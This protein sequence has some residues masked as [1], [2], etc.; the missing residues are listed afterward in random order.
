MVIIAIAQERRGFLGAENVTELL[1]EIRWQT[2]AA[3]LTRS[4]E[5]KS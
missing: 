5:T 2:P 1:G 4:R 3:G